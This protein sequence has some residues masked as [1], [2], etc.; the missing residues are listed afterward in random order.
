[1]T[2]KIT[3]FD[4][5]TP[6]D[7]EEMDGGAVKRTSST[8]ASKGDKLARFDMIPTGPLTQLAEHYG[9]GA[10][11]YPAVDGV[12]NWRL[13]YE[14]SLSY[15]ALQRHVT[16]FW[17]GEDFDRETGS[18]HLVA[19]MW[20]CMALL[21]WSAAHPEFDDRPSVAVQKHLDQNGADNE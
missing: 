15:A 13:G 6:P 7:P 19:A 10:I 20:H 9:K 16:Q 21:E 5:Y 3:K 1:M 17:G 4:V 12:D 8:G 2:P 18:H 11:K 14:W